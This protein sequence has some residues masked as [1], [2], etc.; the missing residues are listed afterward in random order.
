MARTR[1]GDATAPNSWISLQGLREAIAQGDG[2][3]N[4][5]AAMRRGRGVA[6]DDPNLVR[7]A[8]EVLLL[9]QTLAHAAAA[10]Y[11][12]ELFRDARFDVRRFTTADDLRR[13]PVLT[14]RTVAARLPEFVHP[15]TVVT[16]ITSTSGTTTGVRLPRFIGDEEQEA[17]RLLQRLVAEQSQNG[18]RA[19]RRPPPR[20]IVLRVLPAMR[21]YV[22]SPRSSG[23]LQILVT[24]SLH[25]P[26]YTLRSTYDDFVLRQLFQDIPVPGTTGRISAIHAT[27]PFLVRLMTDELQQRSLSP[28]TTG[29]RTIAASG[30]LVTRRLREIVREAWGVPLVTSYS[31]TEFNAV[32]LECPQVPHRYHFDAGLYAEVVDP[33]T[34][35]PAAAGDEG[36]LVL[37]SLHPFQQAQPFIRYA[38]GDL[39]R[40]IATPCRCGSIETTIEFLGRVEHCLDLH[41]IVGRRGRRFVA[42]A[43][44]HDFLDDFPEVPPLLYPRFDL[45]RVERHGGADVRLEFEVY[46]VVDDAMRTRIAR[47]AVQRLR[48]VYHDW[49]PAERSGRLTWD[50]R[51]VSRG[52]LASFLK[53]YPES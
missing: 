47:R 8:R 52:E 3:T 1:R 51:V 53:L 2:G 34:H 50:V 27:P 12:R 16:T 31:L 46:H 42:S 28:R 29:V 24:L 5:R 30:G 37:T 4:G 25:Y 26:K 39:A 14:R 11:Y 21:R 6:G 17:Y 23:P 43:P 9:Q 18:R 22:T 45:R 35:E 19:S 10:P 44:I 33:K 38:P 13:L 7:A 32:A 36:L 40:S 20:D 49:A 41:D 48:R 15:S